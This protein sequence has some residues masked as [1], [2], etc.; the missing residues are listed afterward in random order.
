MLSYLEKNTITRECLAKLL[1]KEKGLSLIKAQKIVDDFFASILEFVANDE[2]VKI[3]MFGTFSSKF[4]NQRVGRNPKTK[5]EF[6][7]P[8]RK[9][10]KFKVAPTLKK[11]VNS[12]V[13]NFKNLIGNV[14]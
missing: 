9:I 5:E 1:K 13:K 14:D 11:R 2:T 10:L 12:N 7:I 6:V 4:K 3:R 8:K